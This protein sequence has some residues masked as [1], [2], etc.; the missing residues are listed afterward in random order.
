[1]KTVFVDSNVFLRLFA[2]DDATQCEQATKLL[3]SAA[4]GFVQLIIGPP[5][6]FEV[7]W[8]LSG[9]YRQDR[10]V[11]LHALRSILSQPGLRV[12]DADTVQAALILAQEKGMS[13]PDAYIVVLAETI[14]ATAVAT[15][16]RKHFEGIVDLHTLG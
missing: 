13:F 1:M 8:A 6:L 7:A 11:V 14:G 12:T 15:F 2:M 10:E 16:N 5:V 4:D 3:Q 9:A